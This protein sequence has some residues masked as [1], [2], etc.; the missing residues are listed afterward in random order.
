[1]LK[2]GRKT[3]S[4]QLND[5]S[6]FWEDRER[7]A[8][9]SLGSHCDIRLLAILYSR[10]TSLMLRGERRIAWSGRKGGQDIWGRHVVSALPSLLC[11][12]ALIGYKMWSFRGQNPPIIDKMDVS[13]EPWEFKELS[14][15]IFKR[16]I[17]ALFPSSKTWSDARKFESR[18]LLRETL[19]WWYRLKRGGEMRYNLEECR[20]QRGT[21]RKH[22]YPN[23]QI[24]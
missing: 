5:W 6:F 3:S 9:R 2:Y 16:K 21:A 19:G 11:N 12:A 14:S 10:T 22:N 24:R 7:E 18:H 1:M 13:R 4:R 20:R 15:P 23:F 8:W 17:S